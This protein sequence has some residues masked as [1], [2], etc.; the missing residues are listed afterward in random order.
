MS[1]QDCMIV[2]VKASGLELRFVGPDE[3]GR[4][5]PQTLDRNALKQN[6]DGS[7]TETQPNGLRLHYEELSAAETSVAYVR[8]QPCEVELGYQRN[9]L[10]PGYAVPYVGPPIDS[11]Q[12]T[13][14][15]N[16]PDACTI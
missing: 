5:T 15:A 6:E 2:L 10:G 7:W 3:S 4:F 12:M 8:C 14:Q 16:Q 11:P 9:L 13:G 1:E